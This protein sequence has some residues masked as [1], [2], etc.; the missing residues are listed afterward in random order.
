MHIVCSSGDIWMV[1]VCARGVID[2]V[3]AVGESLGVCGSAAQ[4]IGIVL[5]A[6]AVRQLA[7]GNT[8]SAE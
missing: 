2:T 5:E 6:V 4:V 3:P 7:D 1:I 8:R